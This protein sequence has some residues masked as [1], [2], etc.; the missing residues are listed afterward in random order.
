VKIFILVFY[1]AVLT[2]SFDVFNRESW[3]DRNFWNGP[4][5]YSE[6]L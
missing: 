5:A 4:K 6:G 1:R 3:M 2:H